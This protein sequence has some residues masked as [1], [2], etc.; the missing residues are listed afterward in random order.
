M[1]RFYLTFL[2]APL[3]MA[4][5]F[6]FP[7]LLRAQDDL[8]EDEYAM[9][10]E[11]SEK[12]VNE[13]A[14]A[15][16]KS[17]VGKF[18]TK[19]NRDYDEFSFPDSLSVEEREKKINDLYF[20]LR[21][22]TWG[23]FRHEFDTPEEKQAYRIQGYRAMIQACRELNAML[24]EDEI[25]RWHIYRFGLCYQML[26]NMAPESERPALLEEL[27]Q[28]ITPYAKSERFKDFVNDIYT[29]IDVFP[30]HWRCFL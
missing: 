16:R 5:P 11:E 26:Y 30:F 24:Q 22:A 20:I 14:G 13:L 25:Q 19:L 4:L 28:E 2:I 1:K 9:T 12:I 23:R 17:A 10:D 3:L 7:G 21:D 27:K 8:Q 6:C 18:L 29:A 15:L